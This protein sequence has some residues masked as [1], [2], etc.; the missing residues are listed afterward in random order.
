MHP[1]VILLLLSAVVA[2]AASEGVQSPL[3]E[4]AYRGDLETMKQLIQQGADVN[5]TNFAGG[6]ALDFAAG[7]GPIVNQVY[8]GSADAV[9]LLLKNKANPNLA[10][11]SG[12]TPLMF[13]AIN[14]NL[15][16][17]KALLEAGAELNAT[18]KFG[19]NAVHLAVSYGH[20]HIA[21][22]LMARGADLKQKDI[23]GEDTIS[24]AAQRRIPLQTGLSW[25]SILDSML[26]VV[27]PL[28]KVPIEKL[29]L[30]S[31]DD[32]V[33]PQTVQA[34]AA[35]LKRNLKVSV[36]LRNRPIDLTLAFRQDRNQ[37]DASSL[38]KQL[39][40]FHSNDNEA[41]I[42][43]TGS[44]L[45]S[46]PL[47]FVFSQ[48]AAKDHLMLI[49]LYRFQQSGLTPSVPGA[50]NF[51]AERAAKTALR[52]I[53]L[54]MGALPTLTEDA[55]VM[56]FSNSLTELDLKTSAYCGRLADHFRKVGMID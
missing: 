5:E 51:A 18:T 54:M 24:A 34:L 9:R 43:V 52:G 8:R 44:D 49:S 45:F 36:D 48:T 10:A 6:T 53:G 50:Y 35:S 56:S 23:N 55:C 12:H 7:G 22:T 17:V 15:E 32:K 1:K 33:A 2:T 41:I 40:Q 26:T 29:T 30:L 11:S 13:A 39:K 20:A 38:L 14:G 27:H 4:A 28:S 25:S 16:S 47:N 37:Y 19:D 46:D 3:M 31:I 21:H 42:A